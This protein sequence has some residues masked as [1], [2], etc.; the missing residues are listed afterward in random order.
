M[1]NNAHILVAL[2]LGEMDRHILVFMTRL[3]EQFT[4]KKIS[5]VHI[6]PDSEFP[7]N[8]EE[9]FPDLDRSIEE[10]ARE[11]IED[12]ITE[13]F[14]P[15]KTPET[16]IIIRRGKRVD[17]IISITE[18]K[19]IDLLVMGVKQKIGG[20]GI[21]MDR[22]AAYADCSTIF[23][24]ENPKILFKQMLAIVDFNRISKLVLKKASEIAKI[25]KGNVS[26]LHFYRLPI[27]YFRTMPSEKMKNKLSRGCHEEFNKLIKK[28]NV[29]EINLDCE[30]LVNDENDRG[31]I[32]LKYIR[33]LDADLLI[34]GLKEK[35]HNAAF[36]I[37]RITENIRNKNLRLPFWVVKETRADR[38][39]I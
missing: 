12:K 31:T 7:E 22:I 15:E 37:Q 6:I 29:T 39:M 36:F 20:T 2:D 3:A 19:P 8:I 23:I 1:R 14:I 35:S 18:E 11:D 34:T 27:S 30:A 17:S 26:A 10:V 4:L 28:M 24:P 13:F 38:G 5:F 21:E 25:N 16:E 32:T 33:R 9:F